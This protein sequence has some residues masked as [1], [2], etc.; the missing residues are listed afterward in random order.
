MRIA[1]AIDLVGEPALCAAYVQLLANVTRRFP[2]E[3]LLQAL[4]TARDGD[5][6]K[7]RAEVI[8]RFCYAQDPAVRYTAVEALGEMASH[9]HIAKELLKK[10][11][12]TE[13]N[14]QIAG[15]AKSYAR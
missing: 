4:A 10:L 15:I 6:E 8:E 1:E 14:K 5:T 12:E 2:L 11:S 3:K 9:S 13:T 7:F